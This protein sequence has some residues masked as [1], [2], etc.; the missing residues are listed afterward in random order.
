M[1]KPLNTNNSYDVKVTLGA[2]YK[3]EDLLYLKFLIYKYL[4]SRSA[5]KPS[6]IIC[7]D[8]NLYPPPDMAG[9]PCGTGLFMFL[10][11]IMGTAL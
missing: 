2:S 4:G 9:A 3:L 10:R 7:Y 8:Q 6:T 1:V 11:I 5:H